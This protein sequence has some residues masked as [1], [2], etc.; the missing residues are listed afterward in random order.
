MQVRITPVRSSCRPM[1]DAP[2]TF[3]RCLLLYLPALIVGTALRISMMAALP[4]GFY[5]PDSN[6]YFPT[7]KR[8]W[9]EHKWSV[10]E[11]RRWVYPIFL[12]ALPPLPG[13]PSRIVPV[14]QHVCGLASLLGVG[15][16]VGHATGRP[17]GWGPLGTTLA[18]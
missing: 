4:E 5:G 1:P 10:G 16:I 17:P 7:A 15:W 8:L 6:S 11:K 14:V 2:F 12:A 18:P 9:N 13:T 3:R